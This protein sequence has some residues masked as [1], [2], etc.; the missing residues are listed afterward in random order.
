MFV[1]IGL[2]VVALGL[3]KAGAMALVPQLERSA[4]T[5]GP[6]SALGLGWLGACLVLSGS[7]VAAS[8]LTLLDGGVLDRSEAFAMLT[9]SRLG[10]SFVVLV[11]G[12]AYAS[13]R[14]AGT[15]RRTPLSIGVLAL[16][17]TVCAYLPGAFLGWLLLNGG[18]LDGLHL[19]ASPDVVAVTDVLFGWAV[20][21]LRAVLPGWGL[22]PAGVVVLL[23]AFKAFDRALPDLG[24]A[25][26]EHRKGAWSQRPVAM[27]LT[28]CAAALVTM[29]VSM[30]I[31]ILVPLVAN[32]RVRREDTLPYVAGANITT[33][34]DT[35]AAA[36]LLGN[37]DA[38]RVVLAEVIGVTAW[39]LLLLGLFYGLLRPVLLTVTAKVLDRPRRL[40][41]FLAA[42]FAVPLALV[43]VL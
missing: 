23:G 32:G 31:T 10:A 8:S 30:A 14:K 26:L 13:R 40:A 21:A 39:T 35:L 22:F 11:V 16:L 28:G 33:L 43:I 4:L 20:D 38:V 25:N 7:P 1:G 9:G 18:S 19:A 34:A 36:V 27:F 42:L 15:G 24:S 12:F 29:S 3:M 6:W 37:A 41:L 5:D 17:M 2:F